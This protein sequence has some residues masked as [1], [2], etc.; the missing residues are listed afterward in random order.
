METEQVYEQLVT[1][2]LSF[3]SVLILEPLV[4]SPE[5]KGGCEAHQSKDRPDWSACPSTGPERK[6]EQ[7]DRETKKQK[8]RKRW[9]KTHQS[10]EARKTKQSSL[11]PPHFSPFLCAGLLTYGC[12]HTHMHTHTN[13]AKEKREE[14][15]WGKWAREE[16]SCPVRKEVWVI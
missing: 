8:D 12:T 11:F 3:V 2:R 4:I 1:W 6:D 14:N 9:R 5:T 15:G 7:T 10:I 16:G 13:R